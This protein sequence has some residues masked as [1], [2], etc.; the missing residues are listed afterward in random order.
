M[1]APASSGPTMPPADMTVEFSAVA[2][3]SSAAG[4]SRATEALRVGWLMPK[5][6]C[7]TATSTSSSGIDPTSSAAC[8][9]KTAQSAAMPPLVKSISLRRS[10]VSAMAPP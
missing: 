3:G 10:T 5:R 1:S 8:S 7:C 9:Q 4:T 6:A 2:A